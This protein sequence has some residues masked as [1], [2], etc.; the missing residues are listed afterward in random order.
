ML[1]SVLLMMV[2]L[3]G[4]THINGHNGWYLDL[5]ASRQHT[6]QHLAADLLSLQ[7]DQG[8]VVDGSTRSDRMTAAVVDG[9]TRSD[10]M[11]KE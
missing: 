10:R 5:D 4:H 3:K 11:A 9:S 2:S 6:T 1:P 7:G 8:A